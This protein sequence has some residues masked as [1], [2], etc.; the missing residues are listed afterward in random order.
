MTG[1][2]RYGLENYFCTDIGESV[3][4]ACTSAFHGAALRACAC[5]C[6]LPVPGREELRLSLALVGLFWSLLA[7]ADAECGEVGDSSPKLMVMLSRRPPSM[8]L[9]LSI[10]SLWV[11]ARAWGSG[12]EWVLSSPII[13]C[14]SERE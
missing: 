4:A 1:G 10:I 11:G 2:A 5:A 8:L 9:R 13:A 12:W 3:V 6:A 7:S 14:D